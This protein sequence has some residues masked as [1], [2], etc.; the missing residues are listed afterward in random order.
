MKKDD[1]ITL[2]IEDMGV[3]GEGIGKLDGFPFFVKDAVIGDTV[4]ARI[5]KMKKSYGYARLMRVMQPSDVRVEPR[6][7]Y[8]RQCGGCQLQ[9][10]SYEAQLEYKVQKVWNNLK[11]I[12]GFTELPKPEIMGMD[13]PWRYRNKAQFPF[14]TDKEGRPVAGFYAARTHTIIPCTECWLGAEENRLVLEKILAYME[15]YRILPYDEKTGKGLVRHVLIRKGFATGELMVCLVLNGRN[16]KN[17]EELV[18]SLRELE[19]MTS[20]MINVNTQNTNVIMGKE[21]IS[22]WGRD[23]ITDYIGDVQ[24]RISPLSFYQ[25]NPMQTKKLYETALEFAD[26][27]GNETVWDLYCGIGTISLFLAQ[28]AGRVYG[29]EVVPEAI[30]DARRNAELNGCSNVEFFV[31]KAE[32]VLPEMYEKDG[33]R[34]DVIV[35]DPPRKGCGAAALETMVRMRP[36]RIVYVSCD[37]ATLARDLKWL[38]ERGYEVG[39]VKGCDMFGETV[40]VESIVL[41]SYKSPDSVINVKVEFGEGDGKVPVDAIADALKYFESNG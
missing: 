36:E 40:H 21:M 2:R 22:V 16:M 30:E 34:A 25:V 4:E 41:L 37:S 18:E 24:Y 6:C 19:G 23:Y 33:I 11:R 15:R 14:G 20:I 39:E 32:E 27:K 1:L 7:A 5:M 3:D 29:V 9:A 8:A 28:R 31:G 35:V 38:C 17:M 10:M 26:L 13:E 12:G